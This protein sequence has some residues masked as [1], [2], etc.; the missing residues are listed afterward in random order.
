MVLLAA[1]VAGAEPDGTV[2]AESGVYLQYVTQC[3]DTLIEHGTDRYG[4]KQTPVLVSILDTE[5]PTMPARSGGARRGMACDATGTAQSGRRQ[6]A[7]GS[8]AAKDH[9]GRVR[10]HGR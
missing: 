9:G 4:P 10:R 6:S 1:T 2:K 5:N 3:L 7:H 8:A